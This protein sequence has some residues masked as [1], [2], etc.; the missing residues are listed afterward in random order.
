MSNQNNMFN[1]D[2]RRKFLSKAD[3]DSLNEYLKHLEKL[4][5]KGGKYLEIYNEDMWYLSDII[6]SSYDDIFQKGG[7]IFNM[8]TGN[9]INNKKAEK[10]QLTENYD[11]E[12]R[13]D[14]INNIVKRKN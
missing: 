13:I 11:T 3:P 10:Q 2:V 8:F 4:S 7:N 5:L 14:R 9:K 6:D 1:K 12:A